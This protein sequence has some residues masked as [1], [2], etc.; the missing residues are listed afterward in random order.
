MYH[1]KCS[2]WTMQNGLHEIRSY[3]MAIG[4]ACPPRPCSAWTCGP[5]M[6]AGFF[7]CSGPSCIPTSAWIFSAGFHSNEQKRGLLLNNS[8]LKFESKHIS[9]WSHAITK[10]GHVIN[11]AHSLVGGCSNSWSADRPVGPVL[12]IANMMFSPGF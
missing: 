5:C 6:P 1:E 8:H 11:L 10:Q 12:S 2:P 7:S 4:R 9:H 3:A